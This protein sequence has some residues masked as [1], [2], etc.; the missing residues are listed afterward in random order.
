[1]RNYNDLLR[2]NKT[3][4]A[5][6]SISLALGTKSQVTWSHSRLV[7]FYLACLVEM[8]GNGFLH[9]HSLLFSCN[10]FPFFPIPILSSVTIS[11]PIYLFPLPFSFPCSGPKYYELT[12]NLFEKNKS[13]ENCNTRVKQEMDRNCDGVTK[14]R[15]AQTYTRQAAC[16][17]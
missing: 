10:Q 4:M 16:N 7:R 12:S 1:M 8:C 5:Y 9:S 15:D 11:I 3:L 13:A 2:Y 6:F 14:S 17:R